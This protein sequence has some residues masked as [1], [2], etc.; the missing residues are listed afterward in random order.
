MSLKRKRSTHLELSDLQE[1]LLLALPTY[2]DFLR[3]YFHQ[4]ATTNDQ[5]VFSLIQELG[6]ISAGAESFQATAYLEQGLLDSAVLSLFQNSYITTLA[7]LPVTIEDP[8]LSYLHVI[9][10]PASFTYLSSLSL[11]AVPLAAEDISEVAKLV[12]LETLLLDDTSIGNS[13]IEQIASGLRLGLLQLSI[14]HNPLVDDDAV[15]ALVSFPLLSFLGL[16]ATCIGIPG[17]RSL[18]AAFASTN[19]IVDIQ[20]PADCERHIYNCNEED[21]LLKAMI[22]G[23]HPPQAPSLSSPTWAR[24]VLHKTPRN[25]T[26]L[27]VPSSVSPT[28]LALLPRTPRSKARLPVPSSVSPQLMAELVWGPRRPTYGKENA[29]LRR[30]TKDRLL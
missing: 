30:N 19:Q 10:R 25:P 8:L 21:T 16:F 11:S 28:P 14:A 5:E 6:E 17:L 3:A 18:A 13:E 12:G 26:T 1:Q 4:D 22:L 24:P 23:Q 9:N 7:T 29:V 20:I 2:K 15:P 27:F